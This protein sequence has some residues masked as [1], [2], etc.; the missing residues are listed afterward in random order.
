MTSQHELNPPP[1]LYDMTL[2]DVAM[3]TELVMRVCWDR[4]SRGGRV[5]RIWKRIRIFVFVCLFYH[6]LWAFFVSKIYISFYVAFIRLIRINKLIRNKRDLLLFV[7]KPRRCMHTNRRH[8]ARGKPIKRMNREQSGKRKE[9][10]RNSWSNNKDNFVLTCSTH[11]LDVI[12][13]FLRFCRGK[14]IYG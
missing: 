11:T 8:R 10:I 4:R 5:G 2:R 9:N 6:C 7:Y 12:I 14:K 3:V 13:W 1:L